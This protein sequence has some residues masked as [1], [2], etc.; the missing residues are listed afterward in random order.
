MSVAPPLDVGSP[1]SAATKQDVVDELGERAL[2]LP[3]LVN[4]GLEANDRAKYLLTL[5]Q[6]AR[7]HA[8]EPTGPYSSLRSERLAAGVANQ[9][10]DVVVGGSRRAEGD[11]Y[12]IPGVRLVH[13]ALAAAVAEMLTPLAG[14]TPDEIDVVRLDALVRDAP[15]LTADRVPGC[16]I[17]RIATADRA[18]GDSF[19]LLVM[20]AHRALNRM[21]TEV[22]TE[23]LD[24]ASAYHLDENDRPLVAAFM[25]GLHTTAPL[26]FDHPGLGTTAT[27][28]G[29]RLL[30]QNDIGETEAHVVVI[31]VE[32]LVVTVTYTDVHRQRLKFFVAMLDAFP[33]EW[34]DAQHRRGAAALGEHHLVTGRHVAP[35]RV[36]L[37]TY[38]HH[39]GS[40]LVFLIDW[41]RARKRLVGLVGK[42][43][44]IELL[45]WAADVNCGHMAF[46]QMGGERLVYDAV[47][48][49]AKVPA[50]YGEPLRDVLGLEATL[51][52]LRFALRATAAGMRNG[53]SRH[54]IRDELRVEVLHH[55]R[56]A[57][58]G[59]LDAAA[60]HASLVVEA[61]QALHAALLRLGTGDGDAFLRRVSE[62]AAV[63]EH[64]ADEILVAVRVAV[65]RVDG[66]DALADLLMSADD[67]IDDLEEVLFLLTLL[68]AE[69]ANVARQVLDD[70][71]GVAVA[72]A[73][74]HLKAISIASEVVA[75]A[76]PDDL[77]DFL[78]AVDKVMTLEHDADDAD[79]LARATLI[80]QAPDFRSLHVADTVSRTIENATD[81]LMRSALGL[82]DHILGQVATP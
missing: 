7:A 35:D 17:E 49:A 38:L 62:R 20:D 6:A 23:T 79:R 24:G 43:D 69:S 30:I 48:V 32:D 41:N 15:D 51:D 34:S 22:A 66:A 16:Y 45:R 10:F 75:G 28:S 73:Q 33:V 64:R 56:A 61:A 42:K 81:A 71:A 26:K 29:A 46:L 3:S 58:A 11:V 39:V 19:H 78:V 27:R 25:A 9:E 47:E 77:E 80:T 59:L 68:P 2:L 53:K 67:A 60:E 54:L 4:R 74:E 40:R 14:R 76:G 44:A 37:Q 57:H 63:W 12:A 18:Q 55:V 72:A 21:Q 52:V 50:R 1:S 36:S 5:L 8:D 82:R 31:T 13:D 70:V 65:R